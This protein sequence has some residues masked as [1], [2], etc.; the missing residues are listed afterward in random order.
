MRRLRLYCA[1][2]SV[3]H[4]ALPACAR[5]RPQEHAEP[6]REQQRVIVGDTYR[7]SRARAPSA[8]P[9]RACSLLYPGTVPASTIMPASPRP[10]GG[11]AAGPASRSGSCLVLYSKSG[12]KEHTELYTAVR[13]VRYFTSALLRC[14]LISTVACS[15]RCSRSMRAA[16]A[17]QWHYR[18][19]AAWRLKVRH[20][21]TWRVHTE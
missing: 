13:R 3:L 7:D 10:G 19:K 11:M 4:P 8:S 20:D 14:I 1:R 6:G 16:L 17:T 21:N 2:T 18:T 5:M 12:N 9:Q 15:C